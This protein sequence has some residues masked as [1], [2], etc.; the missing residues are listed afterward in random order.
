MESCVAKL[1]DVG[2]PADKVN[3]PMV[4]GEEVGTILGASWDALLA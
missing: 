1:R 2:C 3:R 4:A